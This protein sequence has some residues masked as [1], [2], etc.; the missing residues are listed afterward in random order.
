MKFKMYTI[1]VDTENSSKYEVERNLL[2]AL[3]A[4][5]PHIG[6]KNVEYNLDPMGNAEFRFYRDVKYNVIGD[7]IIDND[8]TIVNVLGVECMIPKCFGGKQAYFPIVPYNGHYYVTE[9]QVNDYF[10]EMLAEEG[11]AEMKILHT[12]DCLTVY[13]FCEGNDSGKDC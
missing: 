11:V 3:T 1:A 8:A 10:M 2:I 6:V 4:L 12:D 13:I 7:W 5:E 9:E